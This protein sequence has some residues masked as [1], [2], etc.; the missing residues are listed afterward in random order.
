LAV[1][2][3]VL[4]MSKHKKESVVLALREVLQ[5]D[6]LLVVVMEVIILLLLQHMPEFLLSLP[7]VAAVVDLV[8]QHMQV[9]T[10]VLD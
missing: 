8:L 5:M 6:L 10:V 4:L 2:A 9:E 7:V 3:V 1:E